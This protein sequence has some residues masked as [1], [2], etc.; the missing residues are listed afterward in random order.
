MDQYYTD[1]GD[2]T[3]HFFDLT[4][5]CQY[6]LPADCE[7][8]IIP[9]SLYPRVEVTRPG[10]NG[11]LTVKRAKSIDA[12]L[13]T[14]TALALTEKQNEIINSIYYF[15][16]EAG[17]GYYLREWSPDGPIVRVT[18]GAQ[19]NTPIGDVSDPFLGS[20]EY[21]EEIRSNLASLKEAAEMLINSYDGIAMG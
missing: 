2:G 10:V 3:K 12:D 17:C 16:V 4:N 18:M 6:D 20:D 9:D 21:Q 8:K 11:T 14:G 5:L 15:E 19:S 7:V 13:P 1:N